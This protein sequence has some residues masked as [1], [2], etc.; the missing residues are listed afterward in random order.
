MNLI[1]CLN[2]TGFL[3]YTDSS[4]QVWKNQVQKSSSKIKLKNQ[5]QNLC[6]WTRYLKNQVHIKRALVDLVLCFFF[7]IS[8]TYTYLM[9]FTKLSCV[10]TSLP[11][12]TFSRWIKNSCNVEK[13]KISLPGPQRRMQEPSYKSDISTNLQMEHFHQNSFSLC[14]S[15]PGIIYVSQC[16]NLQLNCIIWFLLNSRGSLLRIYTNPLVYVVSFYANFTNTT[17]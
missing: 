13:I 16:T 17:F 7:F 8:M 14:N 1:F 5:V 15:I 2:Q 9:Q 11:I 6:L 3:C 10:L 4:N 12:P